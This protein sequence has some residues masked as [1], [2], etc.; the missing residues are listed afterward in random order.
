MEIDLIRYSK[1]PFLRPAFNS[2]Y[3]EILSMRTDTVYRAKIT[4]PRNNDFLKKFWAL[5]KFGY[6][7]TQNLSKLP[8]YKVYRMFIQCYAGH[9][10]F[11]KIDGLIYPD[12][13]SVSFAAKDEAQFKIVYKDCFD[14]IAKDTDAAETDILDELIN[15]M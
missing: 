6:F 2:D 8:N 10:K 12:Y 3:T 1:D 15:F 11:I 14:M 13:D 9:G 7:H 4:I 5:M